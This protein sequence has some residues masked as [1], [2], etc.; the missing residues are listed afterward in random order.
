MQIDTDLEFNLKQ[1]EKLFNSILEQ[2]EIYEA[3]VKLI[4]KNLMC[5]AESYN[6]IVDVLQ[7]PTLKKIN[8]KMIY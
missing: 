4:K 2:N 3:N 6:K 8:K 1:L 5:F 7:Y